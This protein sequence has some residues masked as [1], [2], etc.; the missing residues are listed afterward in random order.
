MAPGLINCRV[1]LVLSAADTD[2]KALS[3]ESPS[4]QE[5]LP[6]EWSSDLVETAGVDEDSGPF[7][8]H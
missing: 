6:M 8:G 5:K 1:L 3:V 7:L 2:G 4:S